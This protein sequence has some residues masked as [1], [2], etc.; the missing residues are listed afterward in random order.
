VPRRDCVLFVTHRWSPSIAAHYQRLKQ[1]AGSVL[2][3]LLVY[4]VAPSASVPATARADVAV[5]LAEIAAAFPRRFA[6]RGE[7][8]AFYCADLVW[9]TAAGKA[10]AASYDRVWV[11]EYDVDFSGDWATFFRPALAYDGDL[12][13]I[14]LR[15]LS[16]TPGW[17]NS[18]GYRQPKGLA[19]PLIGFFPAVRASRALIDAYRAG[20]EIEDWAGHF[21]MVLPSFAVS[22]G[23]AVHEIG[24]D[25]DHT[26]AERR[27][28]HYTT[29]RMVG[30]AAAS[31]TFRPPRSF[32]YFVESPQAFSRRNQLY[33]PIK[34]DLPLVD[35]IAFSW[36]KAGDHWVILRNRLLGRA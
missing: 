16:V 11:L 6:E 8:W 5:S 32:R 20:L 2:D 3:V 26:P 1:Q 24:G 36:K 9:M 27:H 34:T 13:G 31:F 7:A 25:T 30:K 23:F 33:H 21:E 10:P 4:Q 28:L 14:D 22:K 18:D 15:P 35:R 29:P 17:W 19:E 12:L